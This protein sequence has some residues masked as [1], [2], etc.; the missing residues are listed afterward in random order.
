M[1]VGDR[2]NRTIGERNVGHSVETCCGSVD[3]CS[4]G[5]V[6]KKNRSIRPI[7]KIPARERAVK[8][9]R[10]IATAKVERI[11]VVVVSPVKPD[12]VALICRRQLKAPSNFYI[13]T[14]LGVELTKI[15]PNIE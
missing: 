15:I 1:S 8:N 2:R 14:D 4:E 10:Y 3:Q 6:V 11:L 9:P 7:H 13:T 5:I 12:K